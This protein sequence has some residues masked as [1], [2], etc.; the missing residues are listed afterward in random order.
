MDL[1]DQSKVIED[2]GFTTTDDLFHGLG[3][4]Y[5]PPIGTS[6]SRIP[7][8]KPD[9]TLQAGMAIVLQPNVTTKDHSAGVQTGQMVIITEDGFE[10]IHRVET[11]LIQINR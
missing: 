8:S 7:N 6:L 9:M 1:V 3:G 4:G 5:L 10:D 11:G 2:S